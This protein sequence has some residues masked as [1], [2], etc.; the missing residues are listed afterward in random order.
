MSCSSH[1]S[2][3]QGQ[4]TSVPWALKPLSPTPSSNL[5]EISCPL[6]SETVAHSCLSLSKQ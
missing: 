5:Q 4:P 2:T 3:G 1:T 6:G